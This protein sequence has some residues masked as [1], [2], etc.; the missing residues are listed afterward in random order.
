LE[1]E[2]N[3][4]QSDQSLEAALDWAQAGAEASSRVAA[5]V[6]S[7]LK[8]ARTAA[9]SGQVRDLRKALDAATSLTA[10]LAEQ[11]A[12][13]RAAYDV[14]EADLLASGAYTKELMAAAA[15]AGLAM[16]EE[17]DR[18]LCY[19]S[20]IRVLPG[21]L[22]IEVDRRRERRLRPTIVVDLLTRTQQAGA[23][24]KPEPFIA[25]LLAAYD[26]VVAAQG[27]TAGAV[28][29]VVEVYAVLTLLPG[30]SKDYT[31]QE[32]ARDL[33]LLDRSGVSTVG[34][35]RRRLRWAAS[36]GTK[37]AGVL[38]T[39]AASGQQQRYWG[40]AFEEAVDE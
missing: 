24:A 17:D 29:R 6:T 20:L 19:P 27:K 30:Q 33:Y 14:D 21:E 10:D 11:L 34:N 12:K 1:T 31:K 13:V 35:P 15:E 22:A 16:F 37:Q 26:F 9:A 38:T 18:L 23:K 25:S 28:V 2:Q 3:H 32:F 36:T 39:V 5:N 8:R 4:R 7:E 40:I